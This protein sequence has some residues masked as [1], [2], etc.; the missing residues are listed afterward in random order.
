MSENPIN[1]AGHR[2]FTAI[3]EDFECLNCG[4]QVPKRKKSY[5]NHCPHCLCSL[6]VDVNPGDRANPCK[7]IMDAIGY[8][9]SERKGVVLIHKCRSCGFVGRNIAATDDPETPDD[10]QRIL[11]IQIT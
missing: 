9:Y 11:E 2:T 1:L 8:E 6:H 7:G 4:K 5:R 10:Y 3:N